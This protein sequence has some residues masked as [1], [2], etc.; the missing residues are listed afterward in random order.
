[1]HLTAEPRSTTYWRPGWKASARPPGTRH[2]QRTRAIWNRYVIGSRVGRTKLTSIR[3]ADLHNLYGE[4]LA[5]G[6]SPTTVRHVHVNLHSALGSAVQ[7]G[8]VARNAADYAHPTAMRHEAMNVLDRGQVA[9]LLKAARDDD[10]EALYALAVT[11]G[12][13]LGELCGLRWRSVDLDRRALIVERSLTVHGQG[14]TLTE[15]K[16]SAS[17][18]RVSLPMIAV[19]ALRRHREAVQTRTTSP[20]PEFQ[21]LVFT[22][23]HGR[24][25]DPRSLTTK[26]FGALLRRAGLPHIRFH[27]LRHTAAPLLLG[28]GE[29]PKVVSSMLSHASIGI[30]LDLYSH[31]SDAMTDR[32]SA[33]MD[34]LFS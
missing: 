26:G 9:K 5:S 31:V 21:D 8:Q 27:D 19:D 11:T 25:L 17:R 13:R 6:L 15:P 14:A 30:T 20:D 1:M 24:P 29:S 33:T 28:E 2:G 3:A 10:L 34:R 4:L 12:M 32:A 23:A 22:R 18:R 7:T 16:S